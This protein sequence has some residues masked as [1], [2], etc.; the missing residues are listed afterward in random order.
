[1][2]QVAMFCR[3]ILAD[4]RLIEVK[5]TNGSVSDAVFRLEMR[6]SLRRSA[7]WTGEYIEFTCLL[8]KRVFLPLRLRWRKPPTSDRKY[9]ERH[10]DLT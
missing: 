9:G 3:S 1:M 10:F 7:Q 4:E 2:E 8:S 5:T 6:A